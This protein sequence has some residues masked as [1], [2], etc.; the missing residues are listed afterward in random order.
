MTEHASLSQY[1]CENMRWSSPGPEAL[2]VSEKLEMKAG[3]EREQR[4]GKNTAMA[5]TSEAGRDKDLHSDVPT[6]LTS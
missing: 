2:R 4:R 6:W 3:E 5:K 1:I